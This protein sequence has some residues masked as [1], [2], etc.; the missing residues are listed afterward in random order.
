MATQQ[1]KKGRDYPLSPTPEPKETIT[2][3][4]PSMGVFKTVKE[5]TTVGGVVEP[6]KY[7]TESIDTAGYAKGKQTYKLKT[8]EGEGDKTGS[9]VTRSTSKEVSRKD[10]PTVLK[11]LKK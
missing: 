9:K 5:R 3:S 8:T 11:S 1:K 2:G 7:K 10:I 6:Y 4:R